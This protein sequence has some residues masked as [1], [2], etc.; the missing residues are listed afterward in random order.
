MQQDEGM[1]AYVKYF[2]SPFHIF[3]NTVCTDGSLVEPAVRR[4]ELTKIVYRENE[5]DLI[6]LD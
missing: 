1:W 4:R 5:M 3:S 6:A 2:F